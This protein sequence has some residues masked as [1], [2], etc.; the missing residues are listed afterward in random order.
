M[1]NLIILGEAITK[2]EVRALQRFRVS[3]SEIQSGCQRQEDPQENCEDQES[4]PWAQRRVFCQV[5]ELHQPPPTLVRPGDC[6]WGGGDPEVVS[7]YYYI[8]RTSSVSSQAAGGDPVQ[9][10]LVAHSPGQLPPQVSGISCP[11]ANTN[12]QQNMSYDQYLAV[13]N[14]YFN[15]IQEYNFKAIVLPLF[16][17]K[18]TPPETM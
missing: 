1:P 12:R 7:S 9:R 17:Y 14:V 6:Q 10:V 2:S 4:A 13:K 16:C 18:F 15:Q 8:P 5:S 11:C 3:P